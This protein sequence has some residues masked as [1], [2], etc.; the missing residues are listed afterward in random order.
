VIALLTVSCHMWDCVPYCVGTSG[1]NFDYC[2]GLGLSG[3]Y[4]VE[5]H[6]VW[7]SGLFVCPSSNGSA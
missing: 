6:V 1:D 4:R 3:L 2:V 7:Y 5:A